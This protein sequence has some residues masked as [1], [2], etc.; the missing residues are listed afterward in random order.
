MRYAELTARI[1][2]GLVFAAAV[3]KLRSAEERAGFRSMLTAMRLLPA[4]VVG[5][6]AV[7]VAASEVLVV[8][9]LLFPST[10]TAGFVLA[11]LLLAGFLVGTGL[12]LRRGIRVACHCFG[13]SRRPLSPVHLGRDVLL[14][15]VA[16][17][18]LAAPSF[19]SQSST[20]VATSVIAA[21]AGALL[22]V[23]FVDFVA[24]FADP[25]PGRGVPQRRKRT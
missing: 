14:L 13:A 18:G 17:T 19:G 6:V 8:L 10:A 1:L 3:L 9:L 21:V 5:S 7:V 24:V 25:L 4:S 2:L 20:E 12:T 22:V 16:V 23:F 11:T 15:A